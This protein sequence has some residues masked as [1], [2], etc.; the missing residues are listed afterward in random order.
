MLAG[1][2]GPSGP[3]F[4]FLP[5]RLLPG[6]CYGRSCRRLL[7]RPSCVT[8]VSKSCPTRKGPRCPTG[9]PSLTLQPLT[10][11]GS[12]IMASSPASGRE[13]RPSRLPD[14]P[15]GGRKLL[16]AAVRAAQSAPSLDLPS[17]CLVG[18]CA[19]PHDHHVRLTEQACVTYLR[20][21]GWVFV[22]GTASKAPELIRPRRIDHLGGC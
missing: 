22:A 8:R 15:P 20:R 2:G 17:P 16:P 14:G 6:C 1:K 19:E 13:S 5:L 21:I 11:L 18:D 10:V 9:A 4:L 12:L 7:W 3:P